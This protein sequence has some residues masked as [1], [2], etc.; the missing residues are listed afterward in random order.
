MWMDPQPEASAQAKKL[1]FTN[2]GEALLKA[3]TLWPKDPVVEKV[4]HYVMAMTVKTCQDEKLE[5]LNGLV[6]TCYQNDN[7]VPLNAM[8]MTT[9]T[10]IDHSVILRERDADK[11]TLFNVGDST[12]ELAKTQAIRFEDA[13]Q[14]LNFVALH[15]DERM[16]QGYTNFALACTATAK[17]DEA[18][19]SYNHHKA[20]PENVVAVDPDFVHAKRLLGELLNINGTYDD[21]IKL[22]AT[23]VAHIF[24]ERLEKATVMAKNIREAT[25]T[26]I[27]SEWEALVGGRV[28]DILPIIRQSCRISRSW[29]SMISVTGTFARPARFLEVYRIPPGPGERPQVQGWGGRAE[30]ARWPREDL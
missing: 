11:L 15:I 24:G 5:V 21:Q 4:A 22:R 1:D 28:G 6:M 19:A 3:K 18:V 30:L 16:H 10:E 29:V 17:L 14:I 23:N 27:T 20:D 13:A 8:T 25:L 26:S 9:T 7:F 12:I 2:F